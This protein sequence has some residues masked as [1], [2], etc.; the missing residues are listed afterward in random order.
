MQ[1][2]VSLPFSVR[3]VEA[4]HSS[5]Q[6]RGES[7]ARRSSPAEMPCNF[8]EGVRAAREK[9]HFLSVKLSISYLYLYECC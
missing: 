7:V 2:P 4:V 6:L 9:A 3:K 1:K 8:E 5:A